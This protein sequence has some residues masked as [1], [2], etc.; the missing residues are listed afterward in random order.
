MPLLV[1]ACGCRVRR[2]R[3]GSTSWWLFDASEIHDDAEALAVPIVVAM[4][5]CL[6]VIV[7]S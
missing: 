1:K 2:S 4:V 3:L 5:C 7:V 6:H